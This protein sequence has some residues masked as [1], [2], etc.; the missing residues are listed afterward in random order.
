MRGITTIKGWAWWGSV[1]LVLL[2]VSALPL[3]FSVTAA[4][5]SITQEVNDLNKE[6]AARKDKIKQLEDTIATY[7]KNVDKKKLEGVSLKNQ[8]SVL[9]NKAVETRSNIELAEVKIQAAELEIQ[10]LQL[11]IITKEGV[12]AE[13][14]KIIA[15]V[16]R[17][18]HAE[19][20][21]NIIEILVTE[22]TL[23]DFFGRVRSLERIFSDLGRSVRMLREARDDLSIKKQ[24]VDNRRAVYAHLK[25]DLEQKKQDLNEQMVFKQKLLGDTKLSELKYQTLLTS[26]R[27]QYQV[28][29]GEVRSIEDKVR[30]RLAEKD[31]QN[32]QTSGGAPLLSWPTPSRYINAL[33]HDPDYPYRNVF[34]HSGVDIRA[35]HGTPIKAA[36]S[37]Y[38]ARARR[39]TVASCYSYVLIVHTGNISTLYGHLSLVA[40][41]DDQFVNRGD[42]IGYS[43]G[44]P[45]TVGAGPFVTGPHLHFEVRQNGIPVDPL[46]YLVQ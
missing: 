16:M 13:Q 21:K 9:D 8:L 24:E 29:E 39:C 27:A 7:K 22:S 20:Q 10:E 11:S 34:E 23:S 19:N 4:P 25:E 46:G 38:I 32:G 12:I 28:V 45:G 36:A 3:S 5:D 26:L 15:G 37:G 2:F 17:R 40:V 44:T 6:I 42:I 35:S 1:F 43:G 33:F 31:A 30:K 41:N 14:K 18:V